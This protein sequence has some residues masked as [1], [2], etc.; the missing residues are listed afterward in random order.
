MAQGRLIQAAI[1][2]IGLGVGY[3]LQIDGWSFEI[4]GRDALFASYSM[5]MLVGVLVCLTLWWA[6]RSW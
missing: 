3:T 6:W 5:G 2:A 1:F 4:H